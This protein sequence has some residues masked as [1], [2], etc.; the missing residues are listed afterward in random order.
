MVKIN[1]HDL[2]E[3]FLQAMGQEEV[4]KEIMDLNRLEVIVQE[5]QMEILT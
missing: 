1:L 5:G 3:V 4:A 2:A